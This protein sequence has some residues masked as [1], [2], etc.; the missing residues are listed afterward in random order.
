MIQKLVNKICTCTCIDRL[1]SLQTQENILPDSLAIL[2]LMPL[3]FL[4]LGT[5]QS[6][7]LQA[8]ALLDLC[9]HDC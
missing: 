3:G 9:C 6:F 2:E 1:I 5:W 7:L 4:A 8:V